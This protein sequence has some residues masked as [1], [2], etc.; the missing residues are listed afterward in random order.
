VIDTVL[1]GTNVSYLQWR[2]RPCKKGFLLVPC[3][4]CDCALGSL[5]ELIGSVVIRSDRLLRFEV[6]VCAVF[7]CWFHGFMDGNVFAIDARFS[8]FVSD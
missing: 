2:I 3:L 1:C 5:R 4:G 7:S 8:Y 6:T